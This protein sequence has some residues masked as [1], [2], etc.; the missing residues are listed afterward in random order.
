MAAATASKPCPAVVAVGVVCVAMA[1]V[2]AVVVAVFAM[3]VVA[4]LVVA[5]VEVATD[6]VAMRGVW[7][8]NMS[9]G[10]MPCPLTG[11]VAGSVTGSSGVPAPLGSEG[12]L[13]SR[14]SS[15]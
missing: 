9:S 3:L 13:S 4:T 10:A 7:M 1:L 2:T 8:T 6:G 12:S 14:L 15:D 11:S 5:T